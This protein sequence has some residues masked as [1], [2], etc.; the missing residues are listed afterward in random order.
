[1][2][3]PIEYAH[4][5]EALARHVSRLVSELGASRWLSVR[6][7]PGGAVATAEGGG[8]AWRLDKDADHVARGGWWLRVA[9]VQPG[10]GDLEIAVAL[11]VAAE[12]LAG[13]QR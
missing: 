8:P 13:G 10:G 3:R 2:G 6:R 11:V 9:L 4:D 5:W 7:G 1:V 12:R